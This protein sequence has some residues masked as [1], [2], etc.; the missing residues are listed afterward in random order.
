MNA[1]LRRV[2]RLLSV[3]GPGT[4]LPRNILKW[5]GR[6]AFHRAAETAQRWLP[7]SSVPTLG[8]ADKRRSDSSCGERQKR[9][10][11]GWAAII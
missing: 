5:A 1:L 9:G 6:R 2:Q 4:S 10:G 7:C 11:A 3:A 8:W